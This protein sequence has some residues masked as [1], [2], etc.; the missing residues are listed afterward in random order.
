MYECLISFIEEGYNG[1]C[2]AN[3]LG[4]SK[5]AAKQAATDKMFKY[6]ITQTLCIIYSYIEKQWYDALQD[7][8]VN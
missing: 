4:K 3:G 2:W 8:L 6:P 1:R 7:E 5:Q